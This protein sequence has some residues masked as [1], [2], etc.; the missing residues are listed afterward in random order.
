MYASLHRVTGP[1]RA[2]F[3]ENSDQDD[4][5]FII[6][7]TI[8]NNRRGP[9]SADPETGIAAPRRLWHPSDADARS[10]RPLSAAETAIAAGPFAEGVLSTAR[11]GACRLSDRALSSHQ[12]AVTAAVQA[13]FWD[14]DRCA[15]PPVDSL[16]E[17]ALHAL[18]V[19][20]PM[21]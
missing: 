3:P 7:S 12:V 8:E 1:W 16:L 13:N 20:F 14:L 17:T 11:R 15:R 10:P 21:H 18:A 4:T 6:A 19:I 2:A 9:R 5:V